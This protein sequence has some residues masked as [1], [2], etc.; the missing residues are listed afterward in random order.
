M[1]ND[2]TTDVLDLVGGQLQPTGTT[3]LA[4]AGK[5]CPSPPGW[6]FGNI[7]SHDMVKTRLKLIL[8]SCL[9]MIHGPPQALRTSDLVDGRRSDLVDGLRNHFDPMSQSQ[10][11]E[12]NTGTDTNTL[13]STTLLKRFENLSLFFKSH[14]KHLSLIL[15]L[16]TLVLFIA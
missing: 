2:S 9:Q 6:N 14:F 11:S 1:F 10:I 15:I 12:S 16:N 13:T 4:E 7:E 5:C 3:A 8:M